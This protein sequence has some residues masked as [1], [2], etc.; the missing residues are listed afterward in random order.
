MN[1]QLQRGAVSMRHVLG[2][3]CIANGPL[4]SVTVALTG[5]AV[6]GLGSLPFAFIAASVLILLYV[7]TS[8]Q[9]SRHLQ[10]AG[11]IYHFVRESTS[12]RLAFPTGVS[13]L[14][15][16][17]LLVGANALIAPSLF[18]SGA[19]ALGFSPPEWSWVLV[20]LLMLII[21]LLLTYIR[22]RPSLDYGIV[23]AVIEVAVVVAISVYLI[24]RAGG[25]NTLS[26][27]SPSHAVN[28][29]SGVG[30][31][32]ALS[33]VALGGADNVLSL[34]EESHAPER[35]IKRSVLTVQV[36]VIGLYL[37]ASY[38]LT[39]AWGPSKMASFASS[40]SPLLVLAQHYVGSWLVVVLAILAL[41]S[42]IGVNVAVNI[43]AARLIFDMSRRGMLP[44]ALSRVHERF[45]TPT[46]GLLAVFAIE[47]V[48]T[49]GS[50][51]IWGE[52]TAFV[53][54]IVAATA[55]YVLQQFLT[56]AALVAFSRRR[57][58]P[59]VVFHVVVPVAACLLLGYSMYGNVWPITIPGSIG[60]F[61]LAG[62][63]VAAAAW[64]FARKAGTAP[65]QA[66]AA[67]V[68]QV[69]S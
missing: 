69:R 60:V 12:E 45:M 4:A 47:A 65:S 36:A 30:I 54:V 68:T 50:A 35:T 11:A 66:T 58:L 23:T 22:V 5:A 63:L 61:V 15:G 19:V 62:L 17:L 59:G 8:Y 21:P 3:G 43:T 44:R 31:A 48:A 51:V 24:A 14:M 55:G 42:I 29:W 40:G 57:H 46:N 2:Q 33:S 37:L 18:D 7:N 38:A 25:S 16:N 67:A 9:F 64:A 34:G 13:Y 41:N 49:F 39:V 52:S 1:S 32:M 28:G 20:T 26:V 6:Y 56:S 27:F 10:G 53:V